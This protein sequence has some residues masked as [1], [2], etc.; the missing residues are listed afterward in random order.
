M[1]ARSRKKGR[2]G[3]KPSTKLKRKPSKKDRR[4]GRIKT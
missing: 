1:K 4:K 3:E 2:K